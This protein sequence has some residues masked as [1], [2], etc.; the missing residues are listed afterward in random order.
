MASYEREIPIR[1]ANQSVT[2]MTD[3]GA[4]NAM[5]RRGIIAIQDELVHLKCA[6]L[7]TRRVHNVYAMLIRVYAPGRLADPLFVPGFQRKTL[8]S[9]M[10][11]L[12]MRMLEEGCFGEGKPTHFTFAE[13]RSPLLGTVS[14]A[15]ESTPARAKLLP[16]ESVTGWHDHPAAWYASTMD[17]G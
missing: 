16:R 15:H 12:R 11:N 2:H 8:L 14:F 3:C 10:G 17:S 6:H 1:I 13:C 9:M 5:Q 7:G 4:S